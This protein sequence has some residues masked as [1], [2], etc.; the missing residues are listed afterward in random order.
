MPLRKATS[1][2]D[3]PPEAVRSLQSRHG[4]PHGHPYRPAH[5]AETVERHSAGQSG[6]NGHDLTQKE[7]H[8]HGG[9]QHVD[10]INRAGWRCPAPASAAHMTGTRCSRSSGHHYGQNRDQRIIG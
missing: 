1:L 9:E 5:R 2:H 6:G 10:G 3:A 4:R 8:Q 7:K